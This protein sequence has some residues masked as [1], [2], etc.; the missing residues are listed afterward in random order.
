MSDLSYRV[1]AFCCRVFLRL[2]SRV[3]VIGLEHIPC[4][5]GCLLV[6]NHIS[7]F[8]PPYLGMMTPRPVDYMADLPLFRIPVLGWLIKTWNAIPFDRDKA[9]DRGAIKTALARIQAGRLVG[10][11]PDRGLRYGEKS[12]LGGAP[13]PPG[14]AAIWQM[15]RAPLVPAVIIG[16]DQLYRWQNL[17]KRP[18]VWV[19][20]GEPLE[21]C[22]EKEETREAARE[23]LQNALN[24]LYAQTLEREN[25][26]PHELPR[27]A[28]ERWVES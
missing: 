3:R 26:L 28:Q 11:F 25:I 27:T 9:V 19:V 10:I 14:T 13:I 24:R 18:R 7:H 6:A 5:G 2:A 1:G 21:P 23:R 15:T 12:I 16:S 17:F 20:Y 22:G 8:D 4:R